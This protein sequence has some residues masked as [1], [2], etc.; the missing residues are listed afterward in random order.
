VAGWISK[1]I[2]ESR[3]PLEV[4]EVG[5][6]RL[7]YAAEWISK[8]RS[9]YGMQKPG[10]DPGLLVGGPFVMPALVAGIHVLLTLL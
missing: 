8:A 4:I 1:E 10:R 7:R 6:S 3:H 2:H 5:N 9:T